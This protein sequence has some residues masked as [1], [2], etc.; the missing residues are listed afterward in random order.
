MKGQIPIEGIKRVSIDGTGGDIRIL[1]ADGDELVYDIGEGLDMQHETKGDALFIKIRVKGFLGIPFLG[2]GGQNGDILFFIPKNKSLELNLKSGDISFSDYKGD[3]VLLR[4]TSGDINITRLLCDSLQAHLTSGDINIDVETKK[5]IL[6]FR[7]GDVRVYLKGEDWNVDISGVSGDLD[8]T[9]E[10]DSIELYIN[11]ISGDV[12][13]NHESIA[14]GRV[15]NKHI[16][17]DGGRN[18][19]RINVVSGDV[20][21]KTGEGTKEMNIIKQAQTNQQ[22]VSELLSTENNTSIYYI[23]EEVKKVRDM[24]KAGKVS[25]EDATSLIEAMGYGGLI[26]ILEE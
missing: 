18:K 22:E 12:S 16:V 6:N 1:P 3:T 26:N 13:V 21:V 15:G 11:G 17:T 4:A 9:T 20:S 23:P 8:V 19:L 25:K 14:T 2:I 24:Y 7:S 10:T 5:G